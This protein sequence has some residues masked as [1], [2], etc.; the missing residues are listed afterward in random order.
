V[1]RALDSTELQIQEK[2][3][4]LLAGLQELAQ[5]SKKQNIPALIQDIEL[6]SLILQDDS[7]FIARTE[8]ITKLYDEAVKN[9]ELIYIKL[10]GITK[11][12]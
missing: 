2:A 7:Q 11:I 3:Q 5:G 12:Q 1:E 4:Q 8:D 10:E 9:M 6:L